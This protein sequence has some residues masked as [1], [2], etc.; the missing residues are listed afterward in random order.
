MCLESESMASL[1]LRNI[2]KIYPF[3][4]D[5]AKKAK[6]GKNNAETKKTSLQITDKGVVAVQDFLVSALFL[7]FL[8]F[9]AS[10]PLYG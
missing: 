10:S 1:S 6:K 3:N 9:F 8:A 4:G 7:P 5:D 2:K